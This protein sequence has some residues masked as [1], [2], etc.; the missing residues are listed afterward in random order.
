[1]PPKPHPYL[2]RKLLVCIIGFFLCLLGFMA[3]VVLPGLT[4]VYT[5]FVSGVVGIVAAYLT[6]N[7]LSQRF[8]TSYSSRYDEPPQGPSGE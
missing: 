4:Q 3:C 6:G 7:V 5:S 2:S 1:M 8:D